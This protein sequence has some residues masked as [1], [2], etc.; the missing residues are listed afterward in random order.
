MP[1]H[2]KNRHQQNYICYRL[3]KQ[4]EASAKVV[5]MHFRI[6]DF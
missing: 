1:N 5:Q 6:V 3:H 2:L 4:V